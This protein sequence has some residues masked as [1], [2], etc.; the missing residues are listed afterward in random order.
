MAHAYARLPEEQRDKLQPLVDEWI[1]SENAGER[2]DV[3]WLVR[4]NVCWPLFLRFGASLSVSNSRRVSEVYEW[5]RVNQLVGFLTE[6]S[7]LE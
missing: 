5:E 4:S 6:H 3:L 1:L 7:H 2:F